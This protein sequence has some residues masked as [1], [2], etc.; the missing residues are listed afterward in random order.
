MTTHYLPVL[1]SHRMSLGELAEHS[2][3]HPAQLRRLVALGLLQANHG[4]DGALRFAAGQLAA[5]DRIE[6]LRTGLSINY[7]ALGLIVEL[8]DRIREL[9]SALRTERAAHDA[10]RGWTSRWTS[11]D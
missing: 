6:R 3:T 10:T 11:A 8:L 7:A 5:L 1:A 2:G 9:E 4:T